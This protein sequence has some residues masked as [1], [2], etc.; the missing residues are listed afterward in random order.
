M[1]RVRAYIAY[2]LV[3][4]ALRVHN[5]LTNVL[6]REIVRAEMQVQFE[7]AGITGFVPEQNDETGVVTMTPVFKGSHTV[8]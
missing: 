2:R 5:N 7:A 3:R 6:A 8:H 4:L 1:D